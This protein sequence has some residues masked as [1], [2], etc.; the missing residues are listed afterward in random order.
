MSPETTTPVEKR[1]GGRL[2]N[3]ALI[4]AAVLLPVIAS[5]LL[6]SRF[7]PARTLPPAIG[8]EASLGITDL[9]RRVKADLGAAQADME[10]HHE[11]ALFRLEDFDLEISFVVRAADGVH[12]KTGYELVAVEG[13]SRIE[14]EKVQRLKLHMR[15]VDPTRVQQPSQAGVT[16]GPDAITLGEPPPA[17][18]RR[19]Q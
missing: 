18:E 19:K 13:D 3:S 14:S 17:R 5:G 4:V 12:A 15:V 7:I 6:R 1:A 11:M 2:R 8:P 10:R 16:A 9:I